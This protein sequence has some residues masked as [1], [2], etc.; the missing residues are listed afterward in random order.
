MIELKRDSEF[1]I[2][3]NVLDVWKIYS[4]E[5]NIKIDTISAIEEK[6]DNGEAVKI[7]CGENYK[8]FNIIK[9]GNIIGHL[10]EVRYEDDIVDVEIDFFLYNNNK[11][12]FLNEILKKY[13][14]SIDSYKRIGVVIKKEN[15]AKDYI[16]KIIL[17]LGFK[18]NFEEAIYIKEVN[19]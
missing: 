5:L 18:Y 17:E 13:L 15:K 1:I 19:K 10:A 8:N 7:E 6:M 16:E 11:G 12:K 2:N 14:E 3:N 4:D 9:D